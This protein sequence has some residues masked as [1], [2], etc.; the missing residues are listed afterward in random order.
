VLTINIHT[1]SIVSRETY[2][3]YGLST[4]LISSS[5]A[6]DQRYIVLGYHAGRIS[7]VD[8]QEKKVLGNEH[9]FQKCAVSQIF[10]NNG[11]L[12]C[13]GYY[14][15]QI[16]MA[17]D[18]P[19]FKRD[20]ETGKYIPLDEKITGSTCPLSLSGDMV[21]SI[22]RNTLDVVLP[23][24]KSLR[25]DMYYLGKY[26][27][28][29]RWQL[30]SPQY[31]P[32]IGALSR[33]IIK[34]DK[35][36]HF[37][38]V[39]HSTGGIFV[40]DGK[41]GN[42][43]P[44]SSRIISIENE[45]ITRLEI[46][47]HEDALII[48]STA[49]HTYICDAAKGKILGKMH[50]IN[51]L[52]V[53]SPDVFVMHSQLYESKAIANTC[54]A[55]VK[56][57]P[58]LH[59]DDMGRIFKALKENTSVNEIVIKKTL[60][61]QS[62]T[63][64][65]DLLRARPNLKI[66]VGP[67]LKLALNLE[68]QSVA[69]TLTLQEEY[70]KR[71]KAFEEKMNSTTVPLTQKIRELEAKSIQTDLELKRLKTNHEEKEKQLLE[72]LKVY[73]TSFDDI[74]KEA[75][76]NFEQEYK[77][78]LQDFKQAENETKLFR[79]QITQL[80]AQVRTLE[81]EANDPKS[82]YRKLL[83][84]GA[85]QGDSKS[86][87]EALRVIG[88]NTPND[89]GE[90]AIFHSELHNHPDTTDELLTASA[91]ICA[92]DKEGHT[93]LYKAAEMKNLEAVKHILKNFPTDDVEA[94]ALLAAL[95][96]TTTQEIYQAI[97]TKLLFQAAKQDNPNSEAL[98][99]RAIECRADVNA[100][101]DDFE[102]PLHKACFSG[103]AVI[104]SLLLKH[105]SKTDITDSQG[106]NPIELARDDNIKKLITDH[107]RL[108]EKGRV[109][110]HDVLT[111]FRKKKIQ[112]HIIEPLKGNI[113]KESNEIIAEWCNKK[114]YGKVSALTQALQQKDY[115]RAKQLILEKP[116]KEMEHKSGFKVKY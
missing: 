25:A 44:Y 112:K 45:N 74:F 101:G 82:H 8:T 7:V 89:K 5:L 72:V 21:A 55:I 51:Q 87:K 40:C 14:P 20:G 27:F 43:S 46:L 73:F 104:V 42:I 70:H 53:L 56:R 22:D 41:N 93:V 58:I 92:E 90:T 75:T 23:Q 113:I 36:T 71:L 31:N 38:Y 29:N 47:S 62:F 34:K 85:E 97:A 60:D 32:N 26:Q 116:E 106:R 64:L 78:K 68:V 84:N 83:M 95:T 66:Q 114:E 110:K 18:T 50:L 49:E 94:K 63:A 108:L 17:P 48:F 102:T 69:K 30:Q 91:D 80:T 98:A 4:G 65:L 61:H 105:G 39:G 16:W 57:H 76:K 59:D 54:P 19:D 37:I 2:S 6:L 86:I 33:F 77:K 1:N 10:R 107:E 3:A 15:N 100:I 96:S 88:V 24:G 111:L 109:I 12:F 115:H 9:I 81:R 11:K 13:L 79:E 103:K 28:G 52:Q 35:T 99:K 67:A